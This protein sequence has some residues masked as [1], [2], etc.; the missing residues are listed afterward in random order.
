MWKIRPEFFG[1]QSDGACAALLW[2]F[3]LVWRILPRKAHRFELLIS[4]MKF[5]LGHFRLGS[6]TYYKWKHRGFVF[7]IDLFLF[8]YLRS[9]DNKRRTGWKWL[10]SCLFA[11]FCSPLVNKPCK[12]LHAP[13]NI[14][15]PLLKK[16]YRSALTG[17]EQVQAVADPAHSSYKDLSTCFEVRT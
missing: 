1:R 6:S 16:G 12:L 13:S 17:S 8:S 2:S 7:L 3:S 11:A 9:T 10:N 14:K 15:S 5:K 4:P